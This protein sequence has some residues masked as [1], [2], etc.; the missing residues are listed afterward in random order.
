MK[1]LSRYEVLLNWKE[2]WSNIV[3]NVAGD[4][5]PHGRQEGQWIEKKSQWIENWKANELKRKLK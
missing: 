4:C 5:K 3:A 1:R 2:N